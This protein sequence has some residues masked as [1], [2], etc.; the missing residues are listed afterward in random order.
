[1]DE[2][3]IKVILVGIG[4]VAWGIWQWRDK[5]KKQ[6][7]IDLSSVIVKNEKHDFNELLKQVVE[8]DKTNESTANVDNVNHNNDIYK[9]SISKNVEKQEFTND[10][11]IAEMINAGMNKNDIAR[12]LQ[13]STTEVEMLIELGKK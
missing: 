5:M 1:M 6:E 9:P 3:L 12:N 10:Y 8:N 11:K 2:L 4:L 13:L 7:E